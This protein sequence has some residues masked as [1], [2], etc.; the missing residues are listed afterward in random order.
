MLYTYKTEGAMKKAEMRRVHMELKR[1]REGI[2]P[3]ADKAANKTFYKHKS[4]NVRSSVV[5]R[6]ELQLQYLQS[7]NVALVQKLNKKKA[8]VAAQKKQYEIL[9]K[10]YLDKCNETGEFIADKS[11]QANSKL[12]QEIS[13]LRSELNKKNK[14]VSELYLENKLLRN[15]SNKAEGWRKSMYSILE[16]G[17][18]EYDY[19]RGMKFQIHSNEELFDQTS[20]LVE[21]LVSEKK[22]LGEKYVKLLEL[23]N[24]LIEKDGSYSVEYIYK[25]KDENEAMKK[26][27]ELIYSKKL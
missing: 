27:L 12:L 25:I 4:S 2:S 9:H 15:N 5:D 11:S 20:R 26:D 3:T 19:L 18:K 8:E 10:Q 16:L 22:A 6:K 13:F 17:A 24:H 23:H 1:P 21:Y 14:E 7:E